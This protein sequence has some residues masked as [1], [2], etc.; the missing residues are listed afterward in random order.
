MALS[1]HLQLK[2]EEKAFTD[3]KWDISN[4]NVTG[5]GNLKAWD[6]GQKLPP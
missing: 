2:I 5:N 4:C 1:R 6:M 3:Q